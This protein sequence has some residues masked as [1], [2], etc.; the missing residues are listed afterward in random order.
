MT[1]DTKNPNP[2][3]AFGSAKAPVGLV[4]D[5]AIVDESMAFLEGAL[6]YGRSNFT[7][8]NVKASTYHD[9]MKRHTMKYW[10]GQNRDPVT[11]V[12]ELAYVR[13]C[14]GILIAA[15]LAGTLIDDR[16]P[17]APLGELM[18]INMELVAH[19]KDLFKDHAPRHYTIADSMEEPVELFPEAYALT[20]DP[21]QPE[22]RITG[23]VPALGAPFGSDVGRALDSVSDDGIWRAAEL[24]RDPEPAFQQVHTNPEKHVAN[25]LIPGRLQLGCG[26]YGVCKGGHRAAIAAAVA[27]VVPTG[28]VEAAWCSAKG[29]YSTHR[30]DTACV[31]GVAVVPAERQPP[32]VVC[33]TCVRVP[34]ICCQLIAIDPDTV[35]EPVEL[36]CGGYSGDG[37]AA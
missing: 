8:T 14:A 2:K 31:L 15:E 36:G 28:T 12:K 34:C 37:P 10:N 17:L 19:L 33:S 13:A 3:E 26:C 20:P 29:C 11:R 32:L 25:T 9:A 1:I 7:M 30:V 6:K 24:A 23:M 18:D 4:P 22:E 21:L 5:C 35:G 27:S 16:P